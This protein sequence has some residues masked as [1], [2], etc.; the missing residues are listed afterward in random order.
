MLWSSTKTRSGWLSRLRFAFYMFVVVGIKL[1]V[2]GRGPCIAAQQW[3]DIESKPDTHT[4]TD[5]HRQ[6]QTDTHRHR[7]THTDA[8]TDTH[9]NTCTLALVVVLLFVSAF[10][11]TK[12]L[13]LAFS[14]HI[15]ATRFHQH[16]VA[17]EPAGRKVIQRHARARVC[18]SVSLSVSVF[19]C[20]CVSVSLYPAISLLS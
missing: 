3:R 2:F 12:V 11:A 6:T 17:H 1:S 16:K 20:L 18:L 14:S 13:S 5:T 4:H 7:H 9:I 15:V 10:A 8:H 19:V